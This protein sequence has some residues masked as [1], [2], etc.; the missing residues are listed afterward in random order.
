MTSESTESRAGQ[1]VV[2]LVKRKSQRLLRYVDYFCRH[3]SSAFTRPLLGVLLG[4][5]STIEE[6]VDHY[7]ARRNQAWSGYRHLVATIK[8]I[9]RAGYILL[10]IYHRIDAYRLG[11]GSDRFR[12]QTHAAVMLLAEDV[13]GACEGLLTTA[14]R[15]SLIDRPMT[16]IDE[17]LVEELPPGRFEDDLPCDDRPMA[18]ETSIKLATAFLNLSTAYAFLATP[19][20]DSP[21]DIRQFVTEKISEEQLRIAELRAHNLQ[22]SYDTHIQDTPVEQLDEALL[23]LRGHITVVFHLM[24]VCTIVVHYYERHMGKHSLL[25]ERCLAAL[26][27]YGLTHACQYMRQGAQISRTVLKRYA[28]IV[29]REIPIP[30]YRGFHVRP[31]TLVSQIVMHYGTQ[32]SMQLDD[33]TYDAGS[34]LD[35]FRANESL[36]R[37]KRRRLSMQLEQLADMDHIQVDHDLRQVLHQILGLLAE[38]GAI[39]IYDDLEIDSQSVDADDELTLRQF[40]VETIARLLAM[41]KLDICMDVRAKFV[42]DERVLNDIAILADNGYGED[43]QGRNIPLPD[44]L[45]YLRREMKV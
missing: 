16:P 13:R 11:E 43:R 17:L 12:E 29:S 15:L 36:N 38:R 7:G 31:S 19:R 9:S 14:N 2:H 1:A 45:G 3:D 42:G 37:L 39:V 6:L 18:E 41:G 33:E 25:D 27:Y 34:T 24:Q 22:S 20:S 30:H 28:K 8:N 23:T 40:V 4:E 44:A 32:V 35:L 21:Q 26:T 10:H 5:A